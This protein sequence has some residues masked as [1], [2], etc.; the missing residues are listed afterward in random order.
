MRIP[1]DLDGHGGSQRAWHLVQAL[2]PHGEVHFVLVFRDADYDCV[3]TSLAPLE[4]F[5]RSI[6]RINIKGWQGVQGRRFG[7]V[8]AGLINMIKMRSHEVPQFSREEVRSI[9]A[10]LP[11][12]NPDIIFAGR[13]CSALI[14]QA[15]VDKTLFASAVRLVDFDDVM[16]KFRFRQ[17]RSKD[18]KLRF[19]G[20]VLAEIDARIIAHGERKVARSWHGVSVCTDEDVQ[21]LRVDYPDASIVKI[22]NV[23]DRNLLPERPADGKFNVLFVG[24]LSFAPNI[25]GLR[26]FLDQGWPILLGSHPQ[27]R[28]KV[29]GINPSPDVLALVEK[30][31][32]DLHA[33]APTLQ[34]FYESC[35]VV[36]VPILYGSGTR[37]K[38]LEAMAYGRPVVSTPLGAEGMELEHG[39]HLLLADTMSSFA[40]VLGRL[41]EDPALGRDLAAQAREFQQER[42]TPSAINVAMAELIERGTANASR[43]RA[44]L[45]A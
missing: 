1:P 42:Y 15:A 23:I 8:P 2:R 28:L 22:P 25:E 11:L 13:L 3:S 4:P 30:H 19:Q 36:I 45:D 18:A 6:T 43:E 40:A 27:A 29:V 16:S 20:R 5:V 44:A 10:R 33:N 17:A 34:P 41:A 12:L 35:D 38:I 26:L 32:L 39:R 14:T 31:K 7:F 24:N 9:T 37:I 21:T